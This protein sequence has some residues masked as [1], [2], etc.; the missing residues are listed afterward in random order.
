MARDNLE[1]HTFILIAEMSLHAA[2]DD[3]DDKDRLKG[4]EINNQLKCNLK[5]WDWNLV[6]ASGECL[7]NI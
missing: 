5:A 3:D 6:A 7:L 2:A 4:T 1:L